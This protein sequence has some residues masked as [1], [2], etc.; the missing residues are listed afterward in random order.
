VVVTYVLGYES[1]A[2][3]QIQRPQKS[4]IDLRARGCG[5]DG[6]KKLLALVAKG[7][8]ELL[9]PDFAR[10]RHRFRKAAT[11][12]NPWQVDGPEEHL[13]PPLGANAKSALSSQFR[14]DGDIRQP[15]VFGD[16]GRRPLLTQPR[17]VPDVGGQAVGGLDKGP[18]RFS[19]CLDFES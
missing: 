12:Q 7:S 17:G 14:M 15:E 19:V 8:K 18:E 5:G 16:L 10:G 13:L 6:L 9:P 1:H 3:D 11:A 4:M 2:I